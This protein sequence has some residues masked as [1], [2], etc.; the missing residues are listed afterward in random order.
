MIVS[1][2]F[3]YNSKSQK[4]RNSNVR[5]KKNPLWCQTNRFYKENGFKELWI[6][7][8][9]FILRISCTFPHYAN[10]FFFFITHCILFKFKN[11]KFTQTS[12]YRFL[13]NACLKPVFHVRLVCSFKTRRF[14]FKVWTNQDKFYT[15]LHLY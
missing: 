9:Y 15:W 2:M 10:I 1:R 4:F 8:C 13:R 11:Q 6:C 7:Y 14:P 3:Q 5:R 12:I